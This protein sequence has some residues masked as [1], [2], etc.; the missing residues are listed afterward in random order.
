[1]FS[2]PELFNEIFGI[3]DHGLDFLWLRRNIGL[4]DLNLFFILET[5]Q[6]SKRQAQTQTFRYS[7]IIILLL[8]NPMTH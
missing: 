8:N 2:S 1:M 7:Q 4:S 5:Q 6:R 3:T